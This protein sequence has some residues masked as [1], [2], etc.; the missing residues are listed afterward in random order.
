[1]VTVWEHRILDTDDDAPPGEVWPRPDGTFV[2][3]PANDSTVAEAFLN[4]SCDPNVWM[5]NEVTLIARRAIAAGEELT[6]DYAL[7][8]LDPAWASRWRCRC[9]ATCCRG[10]VTGR[11]FELPELQERYRG[12]FHPMLL[13]RITEPG[14]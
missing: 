5:A 10:A 11:D 4:H 3:L 8:E 12:H 7:F 9:E 13:R 1:M 2:W 6:T 14:P